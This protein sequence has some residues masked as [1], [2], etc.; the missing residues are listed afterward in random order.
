[1][2][3]KKVGIANPYFTDLSQINLII[4]ESEEASKSPTVASSISVISHS[5]KETNQ[6][7][8]GVYMFWDKGL[9]SAEHADDSRNMV[10]IKSLFSCLVSN[11]DV[12]IFAVSDISPVFHPV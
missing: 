4:E 5:G 8:Q 11:Y 7:V 1:M 10:S 12:V 6:H 2:S 9:S 3:F